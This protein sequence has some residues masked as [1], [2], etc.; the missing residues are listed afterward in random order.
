MSLKDP[1]PKSIPESIL[2]VVEPL[3]SDDSVHRLIGQRGDQIITDADFVMMYSQEGRPGVNPV[4][5]AFVT[6]FQF[7]ERLTDRKA[8]EM[9]C[10]RL[11]W[12]YALR[13]ELTWTGF[14][15]SDLCNFRKR[16]LNNQQ[17]MLVFERVVTYLREKGHIQARGK[18]RTDATHIIGNVMRLS[19]LELVWETIRLA[20]SALVSEDAIWS[21]HHL[22][23]VFVESHSSRRSEYRL[24][25]SKVKREMQ[26]AGTDGYWLLK[27]VEELGNHLLDLPEMQHLI[28][29]LDEQ[30]TLSEDGKPPKTRPN[31]DCS[32][33]L[34]TPHDPDV[35]YSN[36]RG[37]GWEGYK[38]Q[39]TETVTDDQAV[40]F[41][42][43]IQVTPA[44]QSDQKALEPIQE[45]L[46]EREIVPEKQYVDQGYMSGE[47]IRTSREQGIDLRGYVQPGGN[48][49]EGFRLTDF[50]ID[51]VR[52]QA[53]CP[54][55]HTSVRWTEGTPGTTKGVAYRAFF[56][57]QC[58]DCPFFSK[59]QC[60]ASPRGR[61]LDISRHHDE[62][63]VRRREMQTEAFQ[64]E[65]N[66]RNGVEG[67]ISELVRAHGARRSRYRGLAKN[68]LQAAFTGATTNL[69]RL[70]KASDLL[71]LFVDGLWPINSRK[72]VARRDLFFNTIIYAVPTVQMASFVG[73]RY[74][75]S[76]VK[77]TPLPRNPNTP[78]C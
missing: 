20:V 32:D 3:L 42:T 47:H 46:N 69:K 55:G 71:F 10:L 52:Q 18:Q 74:I 4:I 15:Y 33:T 62:R 7:L 59:E 35:R 57:K 34:Q 68:Q 67:T 6:V 19:R 8:A 72:A 36:K 29:V 66:T 23:S 75:S 38:L 78:I 73:A 41:V 58:H 45:R 28:R 63:Q 22:P 14:H 76:V 54:A 11:D 12:K 5:L 60:T 37:Q 50:A 49:P 30:F 39:V 17:E 24:S 2:T 9:T 56:G 61:K 51:I 26:Q 1:F 40:N 53:T 16:L 48:K 21:L 13:Q 44:N 27:R 64:Q 65:M 70:A 77:T 31:G 25:D 43:D